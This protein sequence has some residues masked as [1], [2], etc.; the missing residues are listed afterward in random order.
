VN[1]SP[2]SASAPAPA[3]PVLGL[4]DLPA[5]WQ[6]AERDEWADPYP[7]A[8]RRRLVLRVAVGVLLVAGMLGALVWVAAGH[9]SRGVA[10][11]NDG[12]YSLATAELSAAT[13]LVF[14]YR[15]AQA[16]EAQARQGLQAEIAAREAQEETV[17]A[18][19]AQLRGAGARLDAGDAVGVLAALEAIPAVELRSA[20]RASD[21]GKES[22]T[23]MA[24][25]LTTAATAA[26]KKEQWTRAGR[27]AAALLVL[28]PSSGA[29]ATLA[30]RA[31]TGRRLSAKLQ[32][33]RAAARDGRW[34]EALRLALAILSVRQEF[35]GAEALVADARV[36][37]KPKPKPKPT[38]APV[39]TQAP[40]APAPA[41][42]GST[43]T[44]AQPPPP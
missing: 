12:A 15:D 28:R 36:A 43:S 31:E 38:P 16:L 18:I 19:L 6:Q 23:T 11:L 33:A 9:Y 27:F 22:V 40:P 25:D 35:P 21:E 14:P 41:S 2:P 5:G 7:A 8:G 3:P 30:E 32:E 34:R 42:G 24:E 26:L 1:D 37:L 13:V 44:P 39:A 20:V 29:A 4:S 10:A 17:N